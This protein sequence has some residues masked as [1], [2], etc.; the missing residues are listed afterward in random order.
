MEESKSP[1]KKLKFALRLFVVIAMISCVAPFFL[2]DKA[3]ARLLS[4]DKIKMPDISMPDI[5]IPF[6]KKKPP[7]PAETEL[8][9]DESIDPEEGIDVEPFYTFKDE[10]GVTH[11][12]N[13]K[14]N[15]DGYT[16][17][18]LP[19]SKEEKERGLDKLRQ[20]LVPPVE[21]D[22]KDETQTEMGPSLLEPYSQIDQAFDDAEALKEK[23]EAL[24]RERQRINEGVR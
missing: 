17:T 18:Y 14:P 12:T 16:V 11:I 20:A 22:E 1:M 19:K 15:R 2:K 4:W 23:S 8:L 24:A 3:G 9:S 13:Q 5:T 7:Q 6:F 10:N 21:K